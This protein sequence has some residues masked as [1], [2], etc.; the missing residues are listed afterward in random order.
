MV[1]VYNT[2]ILFL[3]GCC[4]FWYRVLMIDCW[5]YE[6]TSLQATPKYN[7]SILEDMFIEDAEFI[8][9]YYLG[10][11]ELKEALILLKVW[12]MIF[13]GVFMCEIQWIIIV[14]WNTETIAC[15]H[16]FRF[17][18]DREVRYMFTTA[19]MGFWFLSFWHILLLSNILAIQWKQ[20]K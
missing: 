14:Q 13:S 9:N 12:Y 17:G 7:S 2:F 18:L 3:Q 10:W 11:K 20:L 4:F 16:W 6:G 8:N 19:W 1:C 15:L 5:Y